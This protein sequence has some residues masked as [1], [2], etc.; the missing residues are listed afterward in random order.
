MNCVKARKIVLAKDTTNYAEAEITVAEQ[1]IAECKVCR[2]YLRFNEQFQ[3]FLSRWLSRLTAPPAL[4]ESL[5]DRLAVIKQPSQKS[6][7]K[8]RNQWLMWAAVVAAFVLGGLLFLA[9][10]NTTHENIARELASM[11]IQD[12]IEIQLRE[13]PLDIETSDKR[14]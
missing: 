10:L 3:Q 13:S 12:H 1:H 6:K 11:L 5:L 8:R 14:K 7:R 4:R 2:E 9:K